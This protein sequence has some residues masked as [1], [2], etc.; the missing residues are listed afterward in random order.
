MDCVFVAR[1]KNFCRALDPEDWLLS[2]AV[3]VLQFYIL[4]F[5]VRLGQGPYFFLNLFCNGNF[6]FLRI[7]VN[8]TII[9][10]VI[11]TLHVSLPK[12]TVIFCSGRH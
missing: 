6:L 3:K 9:L 5:S 8:S 2:F 4:H 12:T 10:T 11:A 1:C 7:R